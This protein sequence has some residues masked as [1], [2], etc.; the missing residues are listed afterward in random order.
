[1]EDVHEGKIVQ[2]GSIASLRCGKNA[3]VSGRRGVAFSPS[4]AKGF[5]QELTT[6][7]RLWFRKTLLD[8]G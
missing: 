4:G 8:V 5:S 1:M 3:I 7:G 2:A 6:S